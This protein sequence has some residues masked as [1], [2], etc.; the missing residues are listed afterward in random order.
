LV[1]WKTKV[2]S[3]ILSGGILATLN[4]LINQARDL[5]QKLFEAEG[6]LSI[7]LELNTEATNIALI[8]KVDRIAFVIEE[9]KMRRD[10]ALNRLKEWELIATR[11]ENS[12]TALQQGL[13]NFLAFKN[14]D[15]FHAYEFTVTLQ[16]NPPKVKIVDEHIIPGEYLI[17]ETVTKL[18]RKAMLEAM[19]SGKQVPGADIE[20]TERLNIKSSQRKLK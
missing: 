14:I 15:K 3:F 11:S 18:D 12:I 1:R 20:R 17:T 6:E 9:L 13:K 4:E 5:E 10:Y 16:S 8:E 7:D 2:E 19:K